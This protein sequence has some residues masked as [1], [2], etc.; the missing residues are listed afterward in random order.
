MFIPPKTAANFVPFVKVLGYK[1]IQKTL[2]QLLFVTLLLEE[3]GKFICTSPS[4][5][6]ST[7]E[8]KATKIL[9]ERP[10][11]THQCD[12]KKGK[13]T[14]TVPEGLNRQTAMRPMCSFLTS[15]FHCY[16]TEPWNPQEITGSFSS[17][18]HGLIWICQPNCS[19]ENTDPLCLLSLVHCGP[20][21]QLL[22]NSCSEQQHSTAGTL[23]KDCK[24]KPIF[25]I[26]IN[27][28]P[29]WYT[30]GPPLMYV[31]LLAEYKVSFLFKFQKTSNF[32]AFTSR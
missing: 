21:G 1:E 32:L 11:T 10:N 25:S 13:Y 2:V 22:P 15:S 19:P 6:V 26:G 9:I 12:V 7:I 30:I 18:S 4:H 28:Q 3:P 27:L 8:R 5:S 17:L 23:T 29:F 20:V 24:C 16:L 14:C 31:L